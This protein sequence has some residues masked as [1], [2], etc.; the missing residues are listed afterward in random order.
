MKGWD[1]YQTKLPYPDAG[2]K[3]NELTDAINNQLLT[4]DDRKARLNLVS[5]QVNAWFKEAV[6]PY[7]E[8]RNRLEQEFW[9]DCRADIGYDAFLNED[10]IAELESAAYQD[11]HSAGYSEVYGC[12]VR[13]SELAEK[14]VKNARK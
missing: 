8:D 11:G 6:K 14:L 10:G 1:E 12:L 3:R 9:D 5:D 13:L 2:A 4:N 7:N